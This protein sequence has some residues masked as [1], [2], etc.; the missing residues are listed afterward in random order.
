MKYIVT[1][2]LLVILALFSLPYP[3][4]TEIRNLPL[5][6]ILL[7]LAIVM[8]AVRTIRYARLMYNAKNILKKYN[9]TLVKT[10]FIPIFFKFQGL[11]PQLF[12]KDGELI[13]INYILKNKRTQRYHFESI[14][15]LF[16]YQSNR[17]IHAKGAGNSIAI[18]KRAQ[19][20]CVGK[21]NLKWSNDVKTR[22][23]LFDKLP[24]LITDSSK[25]EPLSVNDTI[26]ATNVYLSDISNLDQLIEDKY[27]I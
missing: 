23:V 7:S 3:G 10:I 2:A 9:A 19:T 8:I 11:F 22:I 16:F 18:S 26:C 4:S 15:K 17:I 13:E 1:I 27:N 6:I 14:S 21:R 20:S 24:D 12:N 5:L 25:T